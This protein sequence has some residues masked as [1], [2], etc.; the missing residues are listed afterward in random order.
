MDLAPLFRAAGTDGTLLVYD[1]RRDRMLA[2]NP[3]RAAT[4][5]SPASTFKIFNSLI[6]LETGAVKD[7]DQDRLP[8]DGK[9]WLSSD[10]KPIL[11]EVCNGDV[12]LRVAY[13]NSCVPAYQELARRVGTDTYRRL[14]TQANFGNHD[15]SGPVDMFWLNDVLKI[16]A[17]QQIDFLKAV[18]N[19]TLP[20]SARSYDMLADIMVIERT[21]AYTIRA[22][23][24]LADSGGPVVGWWVGWVQRGDDTYL[25]AMNLDRTRPEHAKARIDITRAALRQIGVL[26]QDS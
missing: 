16:S 26:P 11:P 21:P 15:V 23:T 22:K 5:Y 20:Y 4:P 17:Y 9:P 8:W 12:T 24:G 10:G 6:G 1:M 19:R 14:L 13:R 3:E 18:V 25:F 7:T 2:Y